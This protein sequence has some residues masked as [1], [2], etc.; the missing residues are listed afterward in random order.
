LITEGVLERPFVQKEVRQALKMKKNIVL[1]HDEKNCH[2]PTGEGLP[3]DIVQ[4]L[5]VKAVP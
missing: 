1:V 3:E 2:F 5:E 4:I